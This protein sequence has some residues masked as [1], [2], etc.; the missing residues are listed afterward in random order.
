MGPR[1]R[2]QFAFSSFSTEH[3][4]QGV[5]SGPA[6]SALVTGGDVVVHSLGEPVRIHLCS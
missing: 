2:F 3:P 4:F 5:V 6:Q 1:R